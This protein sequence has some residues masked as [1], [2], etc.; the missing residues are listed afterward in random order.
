MSSRPSILP[1]IFF[2]L[3]ITWGVASI[4]AEDSALSALDAFLT[5]PEAPRNE[6]VL[7]V[8]GFYGKPVPL[9]WL[10][11]SSA[12]PGAVVLRESVVSKGEI[13]AERKF[14][15]AKGQE[16]PTIPMIRKQLKVDSGQAFQIAEAVAIR[17]KVAFD[18]AHYQLRCREE[19][20][21]PVWMV[22]FINRAQVSLGF[23]YLSAKD[24]KILRESWIA[25]EI[26]PVET[27]SIEGF[28]ADE[29]ER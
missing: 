20:K 24:G 2:F 29:R 12:Q 15:R 18:H 6:V 17:A 14:R 5:A 21:E 13:R 19:G 16:L 11:L 3:L 22:H 26:P 28:A 8:V 25:P 1:R 10:I 27:S 9:Q 7:G 23:V 4:R